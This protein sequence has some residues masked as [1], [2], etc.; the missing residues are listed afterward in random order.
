MPS[1]ELR[2]LLDEPAVAGHRVTPAFSRLCSRPISADL[3]V[4]RWERASCSVFHRY[5]F[6]T[7]RIAVLG[8]RFGS[9]AVQENTRA[10]GK[11]APT[12]RNS[13]A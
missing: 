2:R 5:Y 9:R 10:Q 7:A 4:S 6:G 8:A 1:A 13:P 11:R 3:L 12:Q